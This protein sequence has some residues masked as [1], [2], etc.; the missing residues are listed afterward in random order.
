MAKTALAADQIGAA[1]GTLTDQPTLLWD[2]AIYAHAKVTVA[3]DRTFANPTQMTAGLHVL[4]IRQD[5]TGSRTVTW[6]T[7]FR[8]PSGAKPL[9][10]TLADSVD[11]LTFYCDGEA[12]YLLG[13][14]RRLNATPQGPVDVGS[15]PLKVWLKASDFDAVANGTEVT[16][17][18]DKSVSALAFTSVGAAT[19][20]PT[21]AR[22]AINSSM[23]AVAC[24]GKNGLSNGIVQLSG[25]AKSFTIFGVMQFTANNTSENNFAYLQQSDSNAGRY[26][27]VGTAFGGVWGNVGSHTAALTP[28]LNA[29]HYFVLRVTNNA[30]RIYWN[31]VSDLA[32]TS[33]VWG[34]TGTGMSILQGYNAAGYLFQGAIAELAIF[35]GAVSDDEK[36]GLE[37]YAR[38][39]FGLA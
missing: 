6:G 16:T 38:A 14:M 2:Q 10:S 13:L 12:M 4:Q 39:R 20:R 11:Q 33:R 9:L 36:S 37:S 28:T 26:G 15:V 8:R 29:W 23:T 21:V 25:G 24:A 1:T 34:A 3:G 31:G 5:S 7:A 27:L 30:A 35:D 17:W 22:N 32:L 18:T 19:N